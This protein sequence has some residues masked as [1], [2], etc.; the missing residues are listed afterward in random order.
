MD[1]KRILAVDDAP[2]VTQTLKTALEGTGH[3]EVREVN[4]PAQAIPAALSFRP[5][6]ILLDYMMPD[7]DGGTIAAYL[8]ADASLKRIPVIFVT[9]MVQ[10]GEEEALGE[11]LGGYPF[12]PKSAGIEAVIRAVESKLR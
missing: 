12:V 1:K 5:D 8:Q 6:L 10:E 4:E 2:S 3:F 7:L 11:V 9:D